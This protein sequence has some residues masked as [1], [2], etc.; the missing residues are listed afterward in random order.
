MGADARWV[1]HTCKTICHADGSRDHWG[2][3]EPPTLE[4]LELAIKAAEVVAEYMSDSYYDRET[5]VRFLS[6]LHK[7]LSR[8]VGH[9]VC[10]TSD[11]GTDMMD[12]EDFRTE[13]VDGTVH[14]LTHEEEMEEARVESEARAVSVVKGIIE[15]Y[16]DSKDGVSSEDVAKKIVRHFPVYY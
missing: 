10:I 12:D 1:C 14:E 11:Y 13:H 15:K 7:W 6:S 3:K 8:H 2:G 16:T 4:E 5:P 9:N